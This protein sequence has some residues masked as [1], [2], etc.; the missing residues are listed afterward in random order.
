MTSYD[1]IQRVVEY[2]KLKVN[3]IEKIRGLMAMLVTLDRP[4]LVET[5]IGIIRDWTQLYDTYDELEKDQFTHSRILRQTEKERIRWFVD[6][7]VGK[8]Q[9]LFKNGIFLY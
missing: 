7:F 5:C 6:M 8:K 2:H 1:A 9:L 4:D 3:A